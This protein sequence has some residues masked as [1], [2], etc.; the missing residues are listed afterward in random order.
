ME[1]YKENENITDTNAI[2]GMI[3]LNRFCR[4]PV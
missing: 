2:V 3:F 1:E 4:M